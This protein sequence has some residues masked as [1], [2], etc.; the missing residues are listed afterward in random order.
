M[1]TTDL[2]GYIAGFLTAITFLPQVIKSWKEN[3]KKE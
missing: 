2:I 3:G 1:N